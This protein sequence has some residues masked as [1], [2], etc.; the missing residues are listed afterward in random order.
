MSR[1]A[2]E[3][4]LGL[5]SKKSLEV[6]TKVLLQCQNLC[7]LELL[8]KNLPFYP[9]VHWLYIPKDYRIN[10]Q[11]IL[12]YNFWRYSS[13]YRDIQGE[14]VVFGVFEQNLPFYP[15]VHWSHALI[16]TRKYVQNI[17]QHH[18]SPYE[19]LTN[20]FL[21]HLQHKIGL[22][23]FWLKYSLLPHCARVYTHLDT[24]K[25]VHTCLGVHRR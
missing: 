15:T 16:N 8:Y 24:C 12:K 11:Q 7:F 19:P 3:V 5:C 2:Q 9:T 20:C 22:H 4:I 14:K 23:H 10:V 6:S 17:L 25:H 13:I 21:L 18:I 1:S